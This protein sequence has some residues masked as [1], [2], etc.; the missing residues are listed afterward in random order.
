MYDMIKD[1]IPAGIGAACGCGRAG[2]KTGCTSTVFVDLG[3]GS[4]MYCR[5]LYSSIEFR[6]G[7]YRMSPA[8]VSDTS[9]G[10]GG[11]GVG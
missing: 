10:E 11:K 6:M 3:W 5:Y 1:F 2:D 7:K 8:A 9:S 4:G